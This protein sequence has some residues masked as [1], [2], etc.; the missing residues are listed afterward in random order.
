M[1]TPTQLCLQPHSP[2]PEFGTY[3]LAVPTLFH[4]FASPPGLDSHSL[5]I[6]RLSLILLGIK[7]LDYKAC[8][9]VSKSCFNCH[10]FI[11]LHSMKL[12]TPI[13]FHFNLSSGFGDKHELGVRIQLNFFK[14]VL[15]SV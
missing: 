9:G 3:G 1:R 5:P 13:H 11:R 6:L 8:R 4:G 7:H 14:I 15:V 10:D 2:F 12:Y